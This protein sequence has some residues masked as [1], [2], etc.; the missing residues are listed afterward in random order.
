MLSVVNRQRH[1]NM[2]TALEDLQSYVPGQPERETQVSRP[3]PVSDKSHGTPVHPSADQFAVSSGPLCDVPEEDRC[4][5]G[6]HHSEPTA[7]RAPVL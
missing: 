3:P 7:G 2:T 6:L 1:Q 4:A 5:A